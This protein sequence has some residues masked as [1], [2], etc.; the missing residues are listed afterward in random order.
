LPPSLEKNKF[1]TT[2]SL[3]NI[4]VGFP[5]ALDVNKVGRRFYLTQPPS[6][7]KNS[8]GDSTKSVAFSLVC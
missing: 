3:E 1:W 2:A 5:F 4:S 8:N 6:L 7:C